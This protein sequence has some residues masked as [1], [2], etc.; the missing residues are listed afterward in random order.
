MRIVRHGER[1]RELFGMVDIA[2]VV[3]D[4]RGVTADIDE[5]DLPAVIMRLSKVD[6]MSLPMVAPS[7]RLGCPVAHVGKFICIGLNYADHAAESGMKLPNEP[8]VFMKATTALSGP[9]DDVVLPRGSEKSDWEVELGVV[10]GRH[11]SYVSESNAAEHIAG[12][13]IVN[14]LS[15]RAFQL[16]RGGQ[17]VKGKSCNTFGPVGPW[18]VTPE[19]IRDPHN[20]RMTLDVNG[21]RFQDGS[22]ATMVFQVPFLVSY[23]S[24][25]MSLEPGDIISTGTPPGVGLGHKPPVY[26]RDGDVMELEIEGLGRQ[27]QHVVKWIDSRQ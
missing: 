22:T 16:E 26:L 11:A 8:V 5:G 4:A 20:L 2:G 18:L 24:Q 21:R 25:F 17:W 6:P 23:L 9:N 1:G 19:E 27:R 7:A 14:D 13:S 10:I 12:Y 15:E 3:R